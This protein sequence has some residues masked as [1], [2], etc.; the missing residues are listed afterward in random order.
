MGKKYLVTGS[1]QATQEMLEATAFIVE[2]IAKAGGSLI[3]GDAPGVDARAISDAERLG[4][5]VTIYAGYKTC[6]ASHNSAKVILTGLSYPERDKLMA[7]ECDVCI[8][9][10]NGTSRGAKLTY[11]YASNLGKRCLLMDFSNREWEVSDG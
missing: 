1:R 9:V 8:A 11:D 10:W 3:V 5:D 6:R 4:I 2:K 7:Q